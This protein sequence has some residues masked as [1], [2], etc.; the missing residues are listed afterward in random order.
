MKSQFNYIQLFLK[1]FSHIQLQLTQT[2][3]SEN[4]GLKR[5]FGEER[6]EVT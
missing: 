2:E 6:N 3:V 4:S 5:M 1:M